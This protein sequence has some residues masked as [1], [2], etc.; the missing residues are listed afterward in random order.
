MPEGKCNAN[1]EEDFHIYNIIHIFMI[2]KIIYNHKTIFYQSILDNKK[3]MECPSVK[4]DS[5]V[6]LNSP[7][8]EDSYKHLA[9]NI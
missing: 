9:N 5:N 3:K 2:W 1:F 7:D 8:M 6:K 4:T